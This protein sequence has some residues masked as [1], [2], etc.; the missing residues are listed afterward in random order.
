MTFST[1]LRYLTDNRRH[2][3][4]SVVLEVER[5]AKRRVIDRLAAGRADSP[6]TFDDLHSRCE[7]ALAPA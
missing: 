5:E 2:L 3:P 6:L 7:R 1:F 4:L